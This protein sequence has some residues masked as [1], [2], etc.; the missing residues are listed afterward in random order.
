MKTRR[1]PWVIAALAALL[2]LAL[3]GCARQDQTPAAAPDATDASPAFED[4][5]GFLDGYAAAQ[6]AAGTDPT[7]VILWPGDGTVLWKEEPATEVV[8]TYDVE[9]WDWPDTGKGLVCSIDD[10]AYTD[11]VGQADGGATDDASHTFDDVPNGVHKLCC[12]LT[13]DGQ[14]LT[15]C[16]ATACAEISVTL[17]CYYLGDTTCSDGNPCSAEACLFDPALGYRKCVFG[18]VDTP[19]CC[20][21]RFDC[22]CSAAGWQ[23]CSEWLCT[24]CAV[25]GDCDDG[26]PCTAGTCTDGAC[27]YEWVDTPEG[28]CCTGTGSDGEVCD[29]GFYCTSDLCTDVDPVSGVGHCAN[30]DAG[31]PD[32]CDSHADCQDGDP[33][34]VNACLANECRQGPVD[35]PLCCNPANGNDDCDTGNPCIIATCITATNQCSYAD[36]PFADQLVEGLHCCDV[37][38]DCMPGGIWEEDGDDDGDPGPDLPSTLDYC[39]NGQCVHVLNP[40]YC[41]CMEG[42]GCEVP[43]VADS[44]ICTEDVCAANSCLHTP[45]AGCC[46]V[47]S[48]CEDPDVCTIESCVD[49][50]CVY[51]EKESCCNTHADCEDGN[52]CNIDACLS[53]ACHHGP[54]PSFPDCCVAD[55]DCEDYNACT[56]EYCHV[57]I[58]TCIYDLV[59]DQD[60]PCCFVAAQCDDD[61]PGTADIC[62]K[63]KCINLSLPGSPCLSADDCWD[64]ESC[65][66][67]ICNQDTLLCEFVW[68]DGCC[69]SDLA[70]NLPPLKPDT[71]EYACKKGSCNLGTHTC[72]FEDIVLCCDVATDC[73]D[74][75]ACTEDYCIDNECRFIAIGNCCTADDQCDDDNACTA[76]YCQMNGDAGTCMI[77]VTPDGTC[78]TTVEDCSDGDIC[79]QDLCLDYHCYN[80]QVECCT[81]ENEAEVCPDANPCTC[82]ACI[83][84]SCRHLP[85]DQ[86][87]NVPGCDVPPTCCVDDD[88]CDSD[89]NPCTEDKCINNLCTYTLQDPCSLTL[90]FVET[91]SQCST[92]GYPTNQNWLED[93]G[94]RLIHLGDADPTANWICS[95]SGELDTGNH[96]RFTYVPVWADFES[97]LVTPGL[98]AADVS[99]VTVQYWEDFDYY[100]DVN[101][102]TDIERGLWVIEDTSAP[103]GP[104][105]GDTF[106]A[107]WQATNTTSDSSV[108]LRHETIPTATGWLTEELY[109]A[110]SIGGE[111]SYAMNHLDIDEV[112]ICEGRPPVFIDP[113]G[114]TATASSRLNEVGL[115]EFTVSDADDSSLSFSIVEGPDFVSVHSIQYHPESYSYTFR[116]KVEA[117]EA[118]DLGQYEVVVAATDGC[119]DGRLILELWVLVDTGYL[120]WEP[121]DGPWLSSFGDAL[122]EAISNNDRVVQRISDI[123]LFDDLTG[124]TGVFVTV[125]VQGVDYV[126]SDTP[127]TD[128]PAIDLLVDYLEDGGRVYLEG[129]NT[130]GFDAATDLHD[131][132]FFPVVAA[133]GSPGVYEGPLKG[134]HFC[135]QEDFDVDDN[136][137]L[138]SS[139]DTLE[140]KVGSYAVPQ[141][142][143]A[144]GAFKVAIAHENDD[145]GCRTIAAS[146]PFALLVEKGAGTVDGLMAKYIY[147]FE[148]GWPP[149]DNVHQCDDSEL[150]TLDDCVDASCVNDGVPGC[151]PCGNDVPC[152]AADPAMACL[153][154]LGYCGDVPGVLWETPHSSVTIEF[155]TPA[156]SELSVS[157][158]GTIQDLNVKLFINHNY[159]GDL[160]VSLS[161]AGE[162][163]TLKEADVTDNAKHLYFTWDFGLPVE[164]GDLAVFSGVGE[165]GTWTL[166]VT[167][168]GV[169]FDG[170]L[171]YWDL[172]IVNDAVPTCTVSE[173]CDDGNAC[174]VDTCHDGFCQFLEDPCDEATACQ[175]FSHCDPD[176]GCVYDTLDC[177]DG[178]PC[179]VDTCDPATGCENTLVQYC[180]GNPCTT[181]ADC[182]YDDYCHY[183]DGVCTA[184]P[185][186]QIHH[187]WD[188]AGAC[189]KAIPDTAVISS[190]LVLSDTAH[191][192]DGIRVKVK[193]THPSSGQLTISLYNGVETVVLHALSGGSTDDVFKVYE[194]ADPADT[195]G[196]LNQFLTHHPDGTWTLQVSDTG[197]GDTGTLEYWTLYVDVEDLKNNGD[198]CTYE[199]ECAS[200]Y[201]GNGFCCDGVGTGDCCG[202]QDDC[203]NHDA[204]IYWADSTCDEALTCQGHSVEPAC[205]DSE[206][207]ITTVPDDSGCDGEVAAP[208]VD[209][210]PVP[211]CSDAE[212]QDDPTVRCPVTCGNEDVE[213]SSGCHCDGTVADPTGIC[214]DDLDLGDACVEESDCATGLHCQNGVCC[215]D[216]QVCCTSW[217]QCPDEGGVVDSGEPL[218][219]V[220]ECGAT[221][222]TC[223][224]TRADKLCE[225]S[226]CTFALADD[227]QDCGA[228]VVHSHCGFYL[229]VYCD[230]TIDQTPACPTSCASDAD[231]D[232]NAHCAAGACVG[233]Y[234]D[235]IICD[236]GDGLGDAECTSAHCQ[237]GF[238]CAA[239]DCCAADGDCAGLGYEVT[240]WCASPSTCQGLRKDAACLSFVCVTGANI[241]DDT[242]CDQLL[243][244][245]PY[246]YGY[247]DGAADQPVAA[248][249]TTCVTDADCVAAAHCRTGPPDGLKH[250]YYKKYDG[251]ECDGGY[252]CVSG[253]CGGPTGQEVCCA[254][255]E[256]CCPDNDPST[257]PGSFTLPPVCGDPGH[258]Q[259]TQTLASCATWVCGGTEV[260]EDSACTSAYSAD[261]I[262]CGCYPSPICDGSSDQNPVCATSCSAD[263]ECVIPCHC[264][265]IC[266]EGAPYGEACDEDSDCL[267]GFCAPDGV[268]CDAACDGTCFSCTGNWDSTTVTIDGEFGGEDDFDP[269]GHLIGIGAGDVSYLITWDEDYLYVSWHEPTHNKHR[270]YL[271]LD[272]DPLPDPDSGVAEEFFGMSFPGDRKPEYAV[273]F[274]KQNSLWLATDAGGSWDV[275]D[276]CTPFYCWENYIGNPHDQIWE[277]AIPWADLPLVD[278]DNG[279]GLWM[280]ANEDGEKNI[281]STWPIDLGLGETVEADEAQFVSSGPGMCRDIWPNTDPDAE[282]VGDCMVCDGLGACTS[283]YEGSDPEDE[284][285]ASLPE[286]CG[287]T[288]NCG[289]SG[290]V[291][292]ADTTPCEVQH[293]AGT[294]EV[295]A[296]FCSGGSPGTCDPEGS[297]DCFPHIC[298]VDACVDPCVDNTHC[299]GGYYC[300]DRALNG[301]ATDGCEVQLADSLYCDEDS[302]CDS[303]HCVE[304][305][306]V[307]QGLDVG[308][309]C[310]T[311]CDG[312]C[313]TCASGACLP[314][315][316][317]TDLDGDCGGCAVCDGAGSCRNVDPDT[318][319]SVDPKFYCAQTS[320]PLPEFEW[321]CGQSG[322][323]DGAGA[324]EKW[325]SGETCHTAQCLNCQIDQLKDTCQADG[326]CGDQGAGVV[327][328][329]GLACASG[330]ACVAACSADSHCCTVS[331]SQLCHAAE[332]CAPCDDSATCPSD[333]STCCGAD[334]CADVKVIPL[335]GGT[336]TYLT[337]TQGAADDFSHA[338][339][340]I[341]APDRV[342]SMTTDASPVQI[343]V[344]VTGTDT[345]GGPVDTY[346]YMRLADC[347]SGAVGSFATGC[348]ADPSAGSCFTANLSAS[349]TYYLILDGEGGPTDKGDLSLEVTVSTF[350]GNGVCDPGEVCGVCADCSPCCGDGACDLLDGE[351]SCTCAADCD[352]ALGSDNACNDGCCSDWDCDTACDQ[353]CGMCTDCGFCAD[354]LGEL[355]GE[356]PLGGTIHELFGWACDPDHDGDPV[357]VELFDN[358]LTTG[359]TTSANELRLDDPGGASCGT[360]V[361]FST[362]LTLSVEGGHTI[363]AMALSLDPGQPDVWL[364][365][366][367][368]IGV[369]GTK[370]CGN[371]G[372]DGSCGTCA[373]ACQHDGDGTYSGQTDICTTGVCAAHSECL[374]GYACDGP[375][376]KAN[377]D[378]CAT[379]CASNDDDYCAADYTCEGVA[380]VAKLP[381]GDGCDESADCISDNCRKEISSGSYYCAAA[382][383]ECSDQGGSGYDAGDTEDPW[384]CTGPN[385]SQECSVATLCDTWMSHFCRTDLTWAAGTGTTYDCDTSAYCDGAVRYSGSRCN[386]LA[387]AAGACDVGGNFGAGCDSETALDEE[388]CAGG[389]WLGVGATYCCEDNG[390]GVGVASDPCATKHS[391]CV[392][393]RTC[394][395]GADTCT[396]VALGTT[397]NTS[398]YCII[399]DPDWCAVGKPNGDIC[400]ADYECA[401]K[402]CDADLAGVNRC[403]ATPSSCVQ[404]ATGTETVSDGGFCINNA[405]WRPCVN[406]TW[407]SANTCTG[408]ESCSFGA[409]VDDDT[410]CTLSA[411]DG[412][413]STCM[414]TRSNDGVCTGGVCG[415]ESTPTSAGLVCDG[416]AEVAPSAAVS[417]DMAVIC[418]LGDCAADTYYRGCDGS[419]S[420][421]C[422]DLSKVAA[423]SWN[424]PAGDAI[425]EN[426]Q[427]VGATPAELSCFT[428]PFACDE[429]DHCAGDDWYS[430]FTCDGV[431]GC[432]QDFGDIGCCDHT[433]CT[434]AEY[435]DT[436]HACK[437]LSLCGERKSGLGQQPQTAGGDAR[438]EC[439]DSGWDG[440]ASACIKTKSSSGVCSGGYSCGTSA[441]FLAANGKVCDGGAEVAPSAA[442]RCDQWIECASGACS[443]SRFHR[444]CTAGGVS[445]N[446]TGWVAD[447]SW[448][449]SYGQSSSDAAG[450]V[451]SSCSTSAAQ[452]DTTDHCFG[453]D[454]YSGYVCNGSGVCSAHSGDLGCCAHS[455]CGSTLYCRLS[456][457]SCQTLSLCGKRSTGDFGQQH[458][459]S[460][461]DHRG[462]CLLE[463]CKSGFCLGT[464]YLCNPGGKISAPDSVVGGT[465]ACSG[466]VTLQ[467]TGSTG[468]FAWYD[469]PSGGDPLGSGPTFDT[470]D[471]SSTTTYYAAAVEAYP[472]PAYVLVF[473]ENC[474]SPW[475]TPYKDAMD[476]LAWNYTRA[477]DEVDFINKLTDGTVW[478]IVVF[479]RYY[480]ITPSSVYDLLHTYLAGGGK[481][482]FS[483]WKFTSHQIFSDMDV[484]YNY[485]FYSGRTIRAWDSSHE[486]YTQPNVVSTAIASTQDTCN[487][488]GFASYVIGGG[489]AVSGFTSSYNNGE[490]AVVINSEGSTIYMAE[491]PHLFTEA[492]LGDFLENQLMWMATDGWTGGGGGGI[493]ASDRLPVVAEI[494]SLAAPVA[495]GVTVTCGDTAT[496]TASGST[497][498]YQWYN[499][500]T[501]GT[502]LDTGST[503]VT[504]SVTSTTDY[505]VEAVE[506]YATSAEILVYDED[507]V[508]PWLYPYTDVLTDMGLTFTQTTS[509]TAFRAQLQAQAWDLVIYN[510]YNY[511]P[512]SGTLDELYDHL[513]AGGKLIY[514]S[515]TSYSHSLFTLMNVG[516][517][518]G[519]STPLDIYA[520]DTSHDLFN[521]PNPIPSLLE[522]AWNTCGTEGQ[523]L[524]NNGGVAVAG[525]TA[526]PANGHAAVVVGASGDSIYMGEVPFAYNQATL[527]EFLENQVAYLIGVGDG[528]ISSRTVVTATTTGTCAISCAHTIRLYDS[529]GDGWNGGKVD[530]YVAGVLVL[531]DATLAS[532]FGP[533]TYTFLA[534]TGDLIEVTYFPGSWS[535]ENYYQVYDGE[536]DLIILETAAS[537]SGTGDCP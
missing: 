30:P 300:N 406:A 100:D 450:K 162:S 243:S 195:P 238:C 528:C 364:A 362:N 61:N 110:W 8:L 156:V 363:T 92:E 372:C 350:C 230:G 117:T 417:C 445:C 464:D 64:Y 242:A 273:K 374:A 283:A 13:E 150:C 7:L 356:N 402:N 390:S 58:H 327:C 484:S 34:T 449:A 487:V 102:Q 208:C 203:Q 527:Q 529:W 189:P 371:D 474:L 263:E 142:E 174:T 517:N 443:A 339:L 172:F 222:S 490:A 193:V 249:P 166:T 341:G 134:K 253:N 401:S 336:L 355:E 276:M 351:N 338:G 475:P 98:N 496:L 331:G 288:G 168:H 430:G 428:V 389:A 509:Q 124:I 394:A 383:R 15:N 297:T 376:S 157:G 45:I 537:G 133:A 407:G 119:L 531:D 37:H 20:L 348:L 340:G 304:L 500:P 403:H 3:S 457:Y 314:F 439:A 400:V 12:T 532:G 446:I 332:T 499:A 224:G 486:L 183:G 186:D 31:F 373:L 427:H 169:P 84:G 465:R 315:A 324:C 38:P 293:C 200:D 480:Y 257:C 192:I 292:W 99:F 396:M 395:D 126:F 369:C 321:D 190:L 271:A 294:V 498:M 425:F 255:G 39:Q 478:D 74:G 308:V 416:G 346:M 86:A 286:T 196:V 270:V 237:N 357:T 130:W 326:S 40:G 414:R 267:S 23:I 16:E 454:R 232:L 291:W 520:W 511:L 158:T 72:D 161:H 392:G 109:V 69:T 343:T 296:S 115:V 282:C 9:N 231:C 151:I 27:D 393:A 503:Y 444:G 246:V 145:H 154:S 455:D 165:N 28:L 256:T 170:A 387:G 505:Y 137:I 129:G 437:T 316:D 225:N 187:C 63:N 298:A 349:T 461:E 248:C 228:D 301:P 236:D 365:G 120:I 87:V 386:G 245:D 287:T 360:S 214:S 309:C 441:G 252:E 385:T 191:Y 52:P 462:E 535:W 281:W 483:N 76:D 148:N 423:G 431:G 408:C 43:C 421:T 459:A 181:H 377:G 68:V 436:D 426:N 451:G 35:D 91:F 175:T 469:V 419:G 141:M 516:F 25:D 24:D 10:G 429:T 11:P 103:Y 4:F 54:N 135:W 473:D 56:A 491:M 333:G 530:V 391:D 525:F 258:C 495:S 313:D 347:V 125:G 534:D 26:N 197:A 284:C 217:G 53:K 71:P 472:F 194:I 66:Q 81:P 514:S 411:W 96:Q 508:S 458:Q 536:G 19:N 415:T 153:V 5:L 123:T 70:C 368:C 163:V 114:P 106:H 185:A 310:A 50:Q 361:G 319:P 44:N 80:Q 235:G 447:G 354:P 489:T 412:C 370:V 152:T 6:L 420:T 289:A 36:L 320:L 60:P 113:E 111:T 533:A 241:D 239:G 329:G 260:P 223:Q 48:D 82:D 303:G 212:D 328:S 42:E 510:D 488:D 526:A 378:A 493:C 409:C 507:C 73:D 299:V 206:C 55:G 277:L 492:V 22:D 104:D 513:N 434:A 88:D 456:D 112:T 233:D 367:V 481:L 221:P 188:E 468:S 240:P 17:Q 201:C 512:T 521:T 244:C 404:D 272:A 146:L 57:G 265:G 524:F 422:T 1:T 330:L 337:S 216:G 259:G 302:D 452:C 250:C 466:S 398:G 433:D 413:S 234:D 247:C 220:P 171:L 116:I 440:C 285:A 318:D 519:F 147:F 305:G 210:R 453:D 227:D 33:C 122:E 167:D 164:V 482:I 21:S 494:T 424:S 295:S 275:Q 178:N 139:I 229:T 160:E 59:P 502:R 121:E 471:I 199:D 182:G 359:V 18:P 176:L 311:A 388:H 264:D 218:Y 128:G 213:C 280:W 261:A 325:H 118:A 460:T 448:S 306:D 65:T 177:D 523:R 274:S 89:G 14:P 75:V 334:S 149:C 290:C 266:V 515:W 159:R 47:T 476:S 279:F 477:Y 467:A 268:C 384:I 405:Q 67:N 352:S 418:V 410:N 375:I 470:P 29:D 62:H 518:T 438:S 97:Y 254:A 435:C 83:F 136:P 479:D 312:H 94:W 226:Q 107:V 211:Q 307:G 127:A 85:P 379:V 442:N 353:D 143:D 219:S 262:D 46:N 485:T 399:S 101:P 78:C 131:Q 140:K 90:P 358:G 95:A 317:F 32:C 205:T 2:L 41:E 215:P 344:K 323:C 251:E 366:S 382:G 380:C 155:G 335:T 345:G 522:P 207:V 108:G 144:L 463:D 397:C 138:N 179:T 132:D 506:S 184:I 501:G 198:P 209:C 322:R 381:D 51:T 278:P 202:A 79:T 497:G 77:S 204:L 432:T 504:P 173:D 269:I 93:I 105:A 49:N 342:F 180:S